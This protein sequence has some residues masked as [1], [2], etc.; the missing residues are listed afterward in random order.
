M[1]RPL[2]ILVR[3][4]VLVYIGVFATLFFFQRSYIYYPQPASANAYPTFALPTTAAH[5]IVS[6]R[7]SDSARAMIYFGGNSE[8]VSYNLPAFSSALPDRAIYLLNYR[9]FGGSSGKPTEAALFED[10]LSLFDKAHAEHR[11]IE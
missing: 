7:P 8:D 4:A 9:G 11:D 6:E 2:I 1:K 3:G 10:G 5:V